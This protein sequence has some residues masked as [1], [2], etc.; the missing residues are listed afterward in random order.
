MATRIGGVNGQPYTVPGQ[1]LHRH[2][3]RLR[4]EAERLD[5]SEVEQHFSR[6]LN[7][8]HLFRR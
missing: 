4:F 8:A 1:T 5:I 7:G 3:Q 2:P 6:A